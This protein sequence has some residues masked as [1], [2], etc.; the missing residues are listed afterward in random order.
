MNRALDDEAFRGSLIKAG[1]P[2]LRAS[3]EASLKQFVDA[4]RSRWL[5]VVKKLNFSLD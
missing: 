2:P 5:D 1:F 4:D 3:S